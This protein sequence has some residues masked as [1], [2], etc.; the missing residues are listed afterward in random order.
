M[1]DSGEIPDQ[2]AVAAG[3]PKPEQPSRLFLNVR[4]LLAAVIA[5]AVAVALHLLGLVSGWFG[6]AV[7][8]CLALLVPTAS[9][10][11]R[12]ILLT[13]M[14]CFGWIVVLYWW[15]LPT[16]G[17]G[18]SGV[19]VAA[20]AAGLTGWVFHSPHPSQAARRLLP[21]VRVIDGLPLL[22]AA[23]GWLVYQPFFGSLNEHQA[24]TALLG[25]WDQVAHFDMVEMIRTHGATIDSLPVPGDGSWWSYSNY[26]E[27]FHS[28]VAMTME[29]LLGPRAA[30]AGTELASFVNAISF[31]QVASTTMVVAG[32]CAIP[33]LR[34][35]PAVVAPAV[36]LVAAAFLLGPGASSFAA[37]FGNFLWAVAL[38]G[39]LVTAVV[40]QDRLV[41]PV[42]IAAIG[43]ALVGIANSWVLVLAL[44]LPATAVLLF[45][46]RRDRWS[47][48]TRATIICDVLVAMTGFGLLKA[49][50]ILVLNNPSADIV[51]HG[52]ITQPSI[53]ATLS[54]ILGSIG[55]CL[56]VLFLGPRPIAARFAGGDRRIGWLAVVPAVALVVAVVIGY[57][58]LQS[59]DELSYYF[60]KY[61]TAVE[62]VCVVILAIGLAALVGRRKT[63]SGWGGS[64]VLAVAS[65]TLVLV[66]TQVFGYTGPDMSSIGVSEASPGVAVRRQ[67]ADAIEHP[68]TSA[69]LL[70]DAVE[71]QR[72]QPDKRVVYVNLP[73]DGPGPVL[74]QM[75]VM[76][77]SGN[78][79]TSTE[80]LVG[81]L[82]FVTNLKAPD[83]VSAIKKILWSNPTALVAVPE[84]RL[85]QVQMAVAD[86]SLESRIVAIPNS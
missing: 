74:A 10:L 14:L 65:V 2:G 67:A 7:I 13:G 42:P 26:P 30:E 71:L 69:Q 49:G 73:P 24:L 51:R 60:F 48:S 53:G 3:S 77:L 32:I 54:L 38:A 43:G 37:G 8:V 36:A 11:S 55:V 85:D 35:S 80:P 61:V 46:L 5:A 63:V 20:L 16:A 28:A 4:A 64:T 6:L 44:A 23:G 75:W 33:R 29:F 17:L 70:L 12:R 45:P 27:A 78:W 1:A 66:A 59:D 34:R 58:Q 76:S 25:G 15:P 31:M 79:T 56:F 68:S 57:F 83:T 86:H 47:G 21:T 81:D 22:V 50:M 40:A 18:R 52:G 84:D 39:A 9:Y 72:Q 41:A 82:F 62:L 19:A